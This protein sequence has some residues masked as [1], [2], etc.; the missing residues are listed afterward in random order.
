MILQ[1]IQ[2]RDERE[3][4]QLIGVTLLIRRISNNIYNLCVNIVSSWA[5]LSDEVIIFIKISAAKLIRF[6]SDVSNRCI[7]HVERV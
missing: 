1:A 6:A 4:L 5:V 7:K 2:F 3:G